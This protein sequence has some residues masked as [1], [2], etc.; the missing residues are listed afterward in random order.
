MRGQEDAG[1]LSVLRGPNLA[2]KVL[3]QALILFMKRVIV[4]RRIV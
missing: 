2:I 4:K 3:A 1:H